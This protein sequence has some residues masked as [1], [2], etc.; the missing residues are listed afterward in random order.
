MNSG[1]V[2]TVI[3]C[4]HDRQETWRYTGKVLDYKPDEVILEAL[5][6]RPDRPFLDLALAYGDRFI[7]IYYT[8]HWY[9]VYEIH[10]GQN[11]PVKGWYCNISLPA[12]FDLVTGVVTYI[13]LALDL[14]VYPDGR[15]VVLD[16][17]EFTAL[18]LPESTTQQARSALSEVQAL[19][20][21]GDLASLFKRNPVEKEL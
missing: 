18:R 2:I 5:F 6:N 11:G 7:E 15:Q 12:E 1:S 10:S 14:W 9:N 3:K 16:E 4:N 8:Q 13:D 17:D 21:S 20:H 19:A